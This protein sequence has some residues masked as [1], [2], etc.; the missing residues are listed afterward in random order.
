MTKNAGIAALMDAGCDHL[1]L[2]DDDCWP[3]RSHW[4]SP[5]V[6]SQ[7]S[8]LCHCWGQT[9]FHREDPGLGV[10]V[11]NWPRGVLLYVERKVIERVGGMRT[12]FKNAGE[13]A[14]FSRRIHNC[15]FTTYEFQDVVE[16]GLG[17]GWW[18]CCDYTRSVPSTLPADRYGPAETRR[19]KALYDRFRHSDEYVEYR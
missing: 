4:W 17:S 19:R 6:R 18:A 9:R 7:E 16:A 14:E 15:G 13:H 8:H 1:F 2:A 10:S 5:Y 3:L 12:E 11:W